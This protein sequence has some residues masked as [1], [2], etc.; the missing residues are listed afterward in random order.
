MRCA[1]LTNEIRSGARMAPSVALSSATAAG[2][3]SAPPPTSTSTGVTTAQPDEAEKAGVAVKLATAGM[4]A[5]MTAPAGSRSCRSRP[6]GG[7][8]RDGWDDELQAPSAR[9]S[10]RAEVLMAKWRMAT[11]EACRTPSQNGH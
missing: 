4:G 3:H 8:T 9:S 2:D 5:P 1:S 11:S 10:P 7:G 6:L